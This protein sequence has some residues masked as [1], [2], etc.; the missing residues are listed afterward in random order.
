M[1]LI[2]AV[3]SLVAAGTPALEGRRI[4]GR[5]DSRAPLNRGART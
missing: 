5:T 4:A 2:R 3:I 1:A